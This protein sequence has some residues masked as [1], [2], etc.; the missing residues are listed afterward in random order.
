MA[1][2]GG[3]LRS[4]RAVALI[5]DLLAASTESANVD[6]K[7]NNS[8]PV[9]I[10]KYI[11]ALANAAAL[12]EEHVGYLVWGVRDS[13]HAVIGTTFDPHSVVRNGQPL[14]F[15]LAQRINPDVAFRFQTVAHPDGR[16]V[17][18]TI[19][20]ATA[21]PVDFDR[22]AYLRIGSATP[23]LADY[24]D[25]QRALWRSSSHSCGRPASPRVS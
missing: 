3:P 11:S 25:R 17:L 4:D 18:L 7:E 12:E 8:A 5:D 21:S 22:T 2:S 13:D 10:G 9:L 15:W 24:P 23:R 20:A 14:P 19:P 16:V 6:F 1:A